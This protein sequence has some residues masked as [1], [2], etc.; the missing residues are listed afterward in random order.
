MVVNHAG[1]WIMGIVQ[2][3]WQGNANFADAQNDH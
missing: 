1:Q 2:S 3:Q